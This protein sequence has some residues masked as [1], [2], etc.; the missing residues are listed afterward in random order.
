MIWWYDD[1]EA[2][3]EDVNNDSVL[4]VSSEEEATIED[5]DDD[6]VLDVSSDE[7][8]TIEDVNDG[9]ET[10]ETSSKSTLE[11]TTEAAQGQN[12]VKYEK[13]TPM[14]PPIH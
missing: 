8:A 12:P 14:P 10:V 2:T 7:E 6:S 13:M 3:I 4:D 5:V 1:E 9:S 11:R